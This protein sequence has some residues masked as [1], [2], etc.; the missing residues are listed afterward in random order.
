MKAALGISCKCPPNSRCAG[1]ESPGPGAGGPLP[2][3]VPAVISR[4]G[5]GA[6]F[7]G[8]LWEVLLPKDYW[9]GWRCRAFVHR[10]LGPEVTEEEK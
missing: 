5:L 3:S 6:A 2:P 1:R 8:W 10:Q 4:S 7:G 9:M